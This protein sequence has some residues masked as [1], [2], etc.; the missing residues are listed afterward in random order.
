[1]AEVLKDTSSPPMEASRVYLMAAFCLV[2][3]LGLG[4][5]MRGS[6]QAVLSPATASVARHSAAGKPAGHPATLE[7]MKQ[8]A[9]QQ[10]APLI[11][12]L[13]ANP[14]DGALLVQ[15]GA[16]YHSSHQFERAAEYYG[17]AVD[18]DPKNVVAR[19]KLAASLYRSGD[20]D[21]AIAQLEKAV[22]Y[23][24]K[25]A[26]ALFDLGMIK[27][28]GKGDSKGA[29]AAWRRLLKTNPQLPEDRKAVVMK[30]IANAM[31]MTGDEHGRGS[32]Q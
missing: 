21:G 8:M 10:A 3:G 18:A 27:L 32:A 15:M 5:L 12:R 13:K 7:Q 29:L 16:I 22:S 6:Q 4:Y 23:G 11:E 14:N 28:E 25:D 19:T 9:D 17:R 2:I 24:P 31:T 30:L 1:M 20:V 26:N